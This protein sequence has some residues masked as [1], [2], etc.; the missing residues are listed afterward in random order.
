MERIVQFGP[1]GRLVGVLSGGVQC[2][3]A[4]T[5]VLPSAGLIP[6]SGPF[7]LHVELAR[8]L[9]EQGIRTFRFEVP[10]VGETPRLPGWGSR[11]ATQ[12]ALDHLSNGYGCRRFVVGG[13]CSAAD[14]GWQAAVHDER[15][16]GL[17]ML[18]GLSFVGPWYHVAR[19][20]QLMRRP[21]R[22]WVRTVQ[23]WM[24]QRGESGAK[25]DVAD[26]REWPERDEARRQFA[27]LVGRGVRSLWV[28]TGGY[29]DRFM[30]PRQFEWSFGRAARDPRVTMHHWPDSDHTFFA[31][32]HRDRLVATIERWIAGMAQAGT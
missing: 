4:L 27:E 16:C 30:H 5:L 7:R 24:R 1:E 23:R 8:R 29:R 3:N 21:A 25:P 26:Y 12:A 22:D 31:R 17:L 6:R 19:L 15:V 14:T 20:G 2:D 28:Y 10:G 13:V 9:E 11:E 18:D 32:A